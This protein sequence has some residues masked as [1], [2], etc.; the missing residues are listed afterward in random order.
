MNSVV[1]SESLKI[2]DYRM[3]IIMRSAMLAA[4]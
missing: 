3:Q 1:S 2:L 4:S